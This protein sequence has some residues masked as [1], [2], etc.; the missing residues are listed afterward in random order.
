MEKQ[1]DERAE[2]MK[3]KVDMV[4]NELRS[5]LSEQHDEIKEYLDKIQASA[6][7]PRNLLNRGSIEEILS[8][9]KLIDENI[10]K[11]K[12]DQPE[13]LVAVNDG[14]IQYVYLVT[15]RISMLMKLLVNWAMWMVYVKYIV[16][17]FIGSFTT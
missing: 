17:I 10:D 8:S 3:K 6:P 4:Y 7:L 11:L 16:Y 2:K 13:D 12:N 9:Q 5:E 14:V 15:L 1:L